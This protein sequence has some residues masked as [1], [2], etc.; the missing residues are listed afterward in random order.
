MNSFNK[1]VTF[2]KNLANDVRGTDYAEKSTVLSG[3]ARVGI[4][5]TAIVGA[6]GATAT[7]VNANSSAGDATAKNVNA[8]ISGAQSGTTAA[9]SGAYTGQQAAAH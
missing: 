2:A 1:L 7:V 5:I 6:A 4:A 8:A 9:V 3:A